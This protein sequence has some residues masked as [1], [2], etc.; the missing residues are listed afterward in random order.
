MTAE[1]APDPAHRR[2]SRARRTA[3][4][5]R[6]DEIRDA[7]ER[8]VVPELVE[9]LLEPD[10]V[11]EARDD[12]ADTLAA[13]EDLRA[14]AP[15][16]RALLEAARPRGVREAALRVL[17]ALPFDDPPRAQALLWTLHADDLVRAYGTT[18]L[19][20]ADEERLVALVGDPAVAV[21]RAAAEA[22]VAAARTPGL[23]EAVG[24]GL[25]DPDPLVREIACR[26]ALYDEPLA[27]T[28]DLVRLL[29]D[30]DDDVR[31]AALEALE[32]FPCVGV[33]LAL[34]DARRGSDAGAVDA[35]LDLLGSRT[36]LALDAATPR[37]RRR[38]ER[39][40]APVRWLL[41]ELERGDREAAPAEGGASGDV[42]WECGADESGE[43]DAELRLDPET[44]EVCDAHGVRVRP[45]VDLAQARALLLGDT[46]PPAAQRAALVA[47][48][49]GDTGGA[50]VLLLAEVARAPAWSLRHGAAVG[51]LDLATRGLPGAT[52][53]LLALARDVEPVVRRVALHALT[54]ARDPRALEPALATL[55]DARAR[56]LAGDAA[57]QAVAA[58]APADIASAALLAELRRPDDRDGLR[59]GAIHLAE[60]LRP[61]GA[62]GALAALAESPLVAG[63]G[64]HVA[65]LRALRETFAADPSAAGG[66]RRAAL[67]RL[68]LDHLEGVDHLDVQAELGAWDWHGPRYG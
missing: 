62:A 57:L 21:R 67:P 59:L 5:A 49:W 20:A 56:P 6:L 22:L 16:E 28:F 43:I 9:L 66:R 24:H 32:D 61:Q 64:C 45:P 44:A 17:G 18:F 8:G 19:D 11:D 7:G 35:A 50:G 48:D 3:L 31:G 14:A 37:A 4:L 2:T 42:P 29:G 46:C 55:A 10:L 58:L 23:V 30:P 39:W 26:A 13:L 52:D 41:D 33:M 65:A 1:P 34:S 38:L 68:A 15:L 53:T 36:L 40:V 63:A 12:V 60:R 54:H 51:L 47:H 25:R 27:L